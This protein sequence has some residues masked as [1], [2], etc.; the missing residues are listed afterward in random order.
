MKFFKVHK[1]GHTVVSIK[2]VHTQED[3]DISIR[4][5]KYVAQSCSTYHRT[6]IAV[7]YGKEIAKWYPFVLLSYHYDGP[8]KKFNPQ[9]HGNSAMTWCAPTTENW[10]R[11]QNVACLPVDFR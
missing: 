2:K 6:I 5:R 11:G 1:D 9:Q 7:E 3:T 4:R 10:D 8:P